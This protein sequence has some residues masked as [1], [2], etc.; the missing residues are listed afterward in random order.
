[1]T[2]T[3]DFRTMSLFIS[4]LVPRL[5]PHGKE[6]FLQALRPGARLLDVGCGNNSPLRAKLCAPTLHYTGLDIGE[7]NQRTDSVALADEYIVTTPDMFAMKIETLGA[8]FDAVISSHNLEHCYEPDRVLVAICAALKPG[9]WL[10]LSFPSEASIDFP[11]RKNN[12]LNFFDDPTHSKPPVLTQVLD[13]IRVG[14]L[15]I[16]VLAARHRP[17]VPLILG[18]LLEPLSRLTKRAMPLGST[19]AL[20]GFETVIWAHKP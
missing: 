19:W 15:E 8:A 16:E 13:A 4:R 6:A 7:Y 10:Y 17:L 5:R 3:N 14:G 20:Y 1:M 18:V 12:T 9:G 2:P 11:R